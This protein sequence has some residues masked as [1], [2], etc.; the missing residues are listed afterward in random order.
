MQELVS[1]LEIR[2]GRLGCPDTYERVSCQSRGVR[3]RMNGCHA[4]PEVSGY[5]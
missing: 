1:A 3:I 2:A 5:I 4:S